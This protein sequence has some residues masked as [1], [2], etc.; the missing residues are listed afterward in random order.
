MRIQAEAW[1]VYRKA[2]NAAKKEVKKKTKQNTDPYLK[3]LSSFLKE[4]MI[5]EKISLGVMNIPTDKIV[6][7]V[8][9]EGKDMY[10][11]D[12]MPLPAPDGDFSSKWCKLYWYYL[13]NKGVRCPITC[14]EYL[15]EFYIL[16]GM[17]RVSIAKCHGVPNITASVTRL[18]PVKTGAP[19]IQR[20]YDFL[21]VFEKT[22]LYEVAF[23]K[24]YSFERF[25]KAL[26]FDP[27]HVWNEEDRLEFLFNWHVF[28]YAFHEAYSGYL[29]ITP[30]DVFLVLLDEHPYEKLR[31]MPPMVLIQL[32]RSSWDKLYAIQNA[33]ASK[34]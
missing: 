28:E 8:T 29:T 34:G 21:N 14:Y 20:Y 33:K 22:G 24:P 23:S 9:T 19:E 25:Q 13:S 26:G 18:L 7:I 16:D 2:N 10:T 30:A 15:G 31:T 17:K 12:F 32:M 4:D 1:A 27:E 11:S 3:S 6:G 5:S